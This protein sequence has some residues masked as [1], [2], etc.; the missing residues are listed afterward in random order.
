MTFCDLTRPPTLARVRDL[1]LGVIG[2]GYKNFY[3]LL[4]RTIQ[5]WDVIKVFH[6]IF[7]SGEAARSCW[8]AVNSN[9]LID[10]LVIFTPYQYLV[11]YQPTVDSVKQYFR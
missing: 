10:F 11:D 6:I 5:G 7:N 1:F 3:P 9:G 4:P 8:R 2:P